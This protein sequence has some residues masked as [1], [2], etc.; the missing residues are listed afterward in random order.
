MNLLIATLNSTQ[1]QQLSFKLSAE[2]SLSI[3]SDCAND[4]DTDSDVTIAGDANVSPT[5]CR[6][7]LVPD[8]GQ[9]E[10]VN[11][12]QSI[13]LAAGPRLHRGQPIQTALPISFS[14]G[15]TRVE[16]AS[17]EPAVTD[18]PSLTWLNG[19]VQAEQNSANKSPQP[20]RQLRQAAEVSPAPSTLTAWLETIGDLQKSVAGSQT[21][22][23]DAARAVFNPG[24]LDG[25]IIVMPNGETSNETSAQTADVQNWKIVASHIPDSGSPISFQADLIDRAV[26]QRGTIFHDASQITEQFRGTQ[27]AV[28]SPVINLAGE[29][30]AVVYGFRGHHRNNSRIGARTLEAQFVQLIANS[31][32][33]ALTRLDK[34]AEATRARV[35]LEQAFSSKVARHL[36]VDPQIL[37][38]R[39]TDVTVLF[40][41]L[42]NF[43]AISE[44][45]G[46]KL[47][48]Q[49]LTD[50]MDKFSE[51]VQRY[52]GVIIDYFGDGLSAFWNA[53]IP[54]TDHTLLACRAANE[55]IDAL[56]ELN[57][58]WAHR[59]LQRLRVGVGIHTGE[60]QV[61][62]SGSSSRLK[63]G[64]QGSTVNI[65]SRLETATKGVGLP[66]L[67][68]KDVAMKVKEHYLGR[69]IC[70]TQLSGISTPMDV[71]ELFARPVSPAMI[72]VYEKYARCLAFYEQGNFVDAITS[73]CELNLEMPDQATEF[74]LEQ[75]MSKNARHVDRRKNV[76]AKQTIK[77]LTRV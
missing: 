22:F 25:C 36:E 34:E 33:S 58:V 52:D 37:D 69:R 68:S 11:C 14:I 72:D 4:R 16:I 18:D 48:Y 49:L 42:R 1:H 66:L 43:S 44:Q 76:D 9:V 8:S 27:T 67:V 29:V 39:T 45:A 6:L 61:G 63:Y 47:T 57:E 19:G 28:V 32:L 17:I 26:Q 24:G 13:V 59:L 38:G 64:P 12:G 41:D 50:V 74:L 54:Q 77:A 5:H 21:F 73:L 56:P 75:A 55:M 2:G 15:D 3:G 51:I 40:A 53:P 7:R 60:A 65:T 35:L 70:K 71:Y 20:S 46:P 62:N 10:I 30:I 23:K 31:I